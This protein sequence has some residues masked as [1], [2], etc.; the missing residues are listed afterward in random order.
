LGSPPKE[1]AGS[2]W[3][4]PATFRN[5]SLHL[6][7]FR[8]DAPNASQTGMGKSMRQY[9]SRRA[10][11]AAC[12]RLA[13][14]N[15]PQLPLFRAAAD[16]R[17][18]VVG[19][20]GAD[21]R[22]PASALGRLDLP[23]VI[24]VGADIDGTEADRPPQCW[25]WLNKLHTWARMAIVHGVAGEA[26]HYRIAVPAAQRFQRLAFIECR[27]EHIAGWA[28][29]PWRLPPLVITPCDQAHTVATRPEAMH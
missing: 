1:T 8:N 5:D 28:S 4:E 2:D 12:S 18:A 7:Y 6:S 20:H 17:I 27:S 25:K 11:Q 14:L 13:S 16:Y 19:I 10:L 9:V 29:L 15:A 21:V 23:T 26:D 22:W 3:R 24:L